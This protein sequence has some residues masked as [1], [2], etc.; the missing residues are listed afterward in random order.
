MQRYFNEAYR[1]IP[2]YRGRFWLRLIKGQIW[3]Q[4]ARQSVVRQEFRGVEHLR[5][6]LRQRAGVV[7][8]ANHCRWADPPV[9]GALGVKAGTFLYYLTSYHAFKQSRLTGWWIRR[10][11]AFSIHREGADREAIRACVRI[12]IDA[13]RPL[14]IFPEGTWFRQNDRLGPLQEGIGLI[15]RQAMKAT[16]RPLSLHPVALKYWYLEDPRPAIR[17][18]LDRWER[19]LGWHP[20]RQF[21]LL[22]RLEKLGSA[23]LALKEVEFFGQPQ[24]GTIEE[25]RLGLAN[26]HIQAL[27]EKYFNKRGSGWHLERIRR[28]R[29]LLVPRLV[30]KAD[31]AETCRLLQQ[32]LSNLL[33]CEGLDSQSFEYVQ[34]DPSPERVAETLLRLEEMVIDGEEQ[35]LGPLGVVVEAAPALDVRAPHFVRQRGGEDP[36]LKQ[37]AGTI[38]AL[39]DRLR[40]EGLPV[41]W[42][43]ALSDKV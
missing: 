20:Q 14:V 35:P 17:D 9:L 12:L 3:K 1:F 39:L 13:D 21:D 24:A 32:E 16:D 30:E 25:R 26:A 15:L 18:R 28:L 11:G 40:A 34:S 5:D 36:L 10:L 31:D 2:P 42:R 27:E 19:R 22:Q 6:S 41:A 37:L 29:Q 38:Q 33:L 8:A 7:L 43:Q 4:L 23:M